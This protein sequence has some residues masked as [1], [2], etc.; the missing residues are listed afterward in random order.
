MMGRCLV[1]ARLRDACAQWSQS[2]Y[3]EIRIKY[4][5]SIYGYFYK[6]KSNLD[7]FTNPI[8]VPVLGWVMLDLLHSILHILPSPW[9]Y[10]ASK[11]APV[12]ALTST[13]F[14]CDSFMLWESQKNVRREKLKA[15]ISGFLGCESK[16]G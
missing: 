9:E 2:N 10:W 16:E 5:S 12:W 4:I 3:I 13:S 11:N 7:H 15:F 1:T 14:S 6:P 8:S